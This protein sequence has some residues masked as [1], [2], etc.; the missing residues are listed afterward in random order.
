MPWRSW[1]YKPIVAVAV[2]ATLITLSYMTPHHSLW[3]WLIYVVAAI[4]IPY[5]ILNR[6]GGRRYY[7]MYDD[8]Y[9]GPRGCFYPR[10][11]NIWWWWWH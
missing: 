2:V 5:A 9:Y 8:P 4:Y 10:T 1:L 3:R 7:N 11:R 6:R